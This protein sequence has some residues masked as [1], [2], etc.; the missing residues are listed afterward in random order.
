MK[1]NYTN[2]CTQRE[3][4]TNGDRVMVISM[5]EDPRPVPPMTEGTVSYIDDAGQIHVIWD[6]GQTLALIPEVDEYIKLCEKD[7]KVKYT[8]VYSEVYDVTAHSKEQAFRK[9]EEDI[10]SG[11]EEG[12]RFCDGSYYKV[13][14]DSEIDKIVIDLTEWGSPFPTGILAYSGDDVVASSYCESEDEF[15]E[16]F[17]ENKEY[18]SSD[19]RFCM[20]A[21]ISDIE[22]I[23]PF[24]LN[25]R[26][27]IRR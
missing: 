22:S 18:F 6:N 23:T 24:L 8:E 26:E 3:R 14:G 7:F 15:M 20:S 19:C 1:A 27:A 13:V 17:N 2:R 16:F 21:D 25:I 10:H 12:P 5:P 4:L 11:Y 9:L